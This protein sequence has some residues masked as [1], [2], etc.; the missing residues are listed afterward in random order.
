MTQ[1][2]LAIAERNVR[3]IAEAKNELAKEPG[4]RVYRLAKYLAPKYNMTV[5][6]CRRVLAEQ[7]YNNN[8]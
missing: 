2:E 8:N 4:L 7:L 5:T 3:L 1:R 6:N